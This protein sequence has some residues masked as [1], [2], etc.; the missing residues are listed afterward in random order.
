MTPPPIPGTAYHLAVNGQATGPYDVSTLTKMVATGQF[1]A[2]SLVWKA[3][4]PT[5]VC[6]DSVDELKGLFGN[7]MPPIPPS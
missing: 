6:A 1:I 7:A 4:M 5:W 2:S 3:G